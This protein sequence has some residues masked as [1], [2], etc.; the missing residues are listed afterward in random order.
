MDRGERVCA[1]RKA[2]GYEQR[3]RQVV[4]DVAD[5]RE[6]LA[7]EVAELFLCHV[8]ARGIDRGEVAGLRIAVE[9]VR[10]D[11]EAVAVGAS[12][13]PH[14]RSRNQ[15]RLEPGLVEPGR[16]D[17]AGLVGDTR[18][19]DLQPALAGGSSRSGRRPR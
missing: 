18:G 17:L 14:R 7:V 16:L 2:V 5:V 3:G 10:R 6:R 12:A 9:V 13:Y 19:E 1:D 8:L 11:G 15:F 4:S